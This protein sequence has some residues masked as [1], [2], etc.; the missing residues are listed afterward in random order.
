M[1]HI[2]RGFLLVVAAGVL[3]SNTALAEPKIVDF[4]LPTAATGIGRSDSLS[5]AF[6]SAP[7]TITSTD[8]RAG[9]ELCVAFL[10]TVATAAAVDSIY[11]VLL[12]RPSGWTTAMSNMATA[13]VTS[14]PKG[15]TAIYTF[16]VK[17]ANSTGFPVYK[18]IPQDSLAVYPI[19]PGQYC[20]G[21]RGGAADAAHVMNKAYKFRGF[22]SY[23]GYE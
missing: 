20:W 13:A 9:Y 8:N 2:L 14:Y 19:A 21:V 3:I 12:H 1:K 23:K 15:W 11:M 5:L 17:I 4:T 16:P 10:D 18:Q 22:V 6:L 7:F